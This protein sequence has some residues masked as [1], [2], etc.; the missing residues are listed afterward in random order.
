MH[1]DALIAKC[2]NKSLSFC[3]LTHSNKECID[4]NL[5]KRNNRAIVKN[6]EVLR[7]CP[8]CNQYL[9]LFRFYTIK[10][11]IKGIKYEYLSCKCKICISIIS[12]SKRNEIN[13]KTKKFL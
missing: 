5:I 11:T 10:R 4:C 8:N 12:K 13:K 3:R 7:F 2:G 1:R 6:S 9:P